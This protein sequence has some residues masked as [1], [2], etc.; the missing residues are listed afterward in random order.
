MWAQVV[1]L[2]SLM[3]WFSRP[4]CLAEVEYTRAEHKREK[5]ELDNYPEGEQAEMVE[6][7]VKRGMTQADAESVIGVMSKYK[8]FFLVGQC[9]LTPGSHHAWFQ[10]L[11]LKYDEPLS[12]IAF[13]WGMRPYIPDVM[14]VE[15]LG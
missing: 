12:N 6:L 15:E 8:D 2:N 10:R 11:R 9:M 14:M 1:V 7:Y 13:N 4:C 5:W 3:C